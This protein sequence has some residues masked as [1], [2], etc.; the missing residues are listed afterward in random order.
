VP[1][2]VACQQQAQ[3]YL[4][5]TLRGCSCSVIAT[6]CYSHIA[7]CCGSVY[8]YGTVQHSYMPGHPNTTSW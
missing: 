5:Q 2:P 1:K 4:I 3:E 7:A 8:W 6:L